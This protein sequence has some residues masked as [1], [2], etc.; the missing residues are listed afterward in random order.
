MLRILTLNIGSLFEADWDRRRHEVVAW[1]DELGPDVVCLQEVWEDASDPNTAGW[2]ADHVGADYHWTFGG[3]P[4]AARAST[5][6]AF[7]F[8]S[9]VL[10]RW[11]IDE[12]NVVAL[13]IAA[14][15]EDP[16]PASMPWELVHVRTAGLDIFTTHLAP[17]PSHGRHRRVQVL[18][19]DEHVR[20]IR[21]DR[22]SFAD[23]PN[24]RPEM[25]AIVCG[26][27]NAEPGSDEIRF[28]KGHTVIADRTTYFQDAWAVA[29]DGSAGHT[30]D[31][32]THPLAASLNVHRKRIDYLFVGDP[33]L[34]AGDAGRVVSCRVVADKPLTGI[35]A[36]DHCGLVADIVWP[37]RP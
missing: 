30:Q 13:P 21:G 24:P 8:G 16:V 22:D 1:I 6:P 31:W 23:F 9:A 7:R 17:A 18:A 36:S 5:N 32:S 11:L 12:R 26:D 15:P 3:H 14:N 29:G 37:A 2:V 20:A 33:F 34:R 25:P 10:S 4:I 19:I 28:L 35:Q 27:F